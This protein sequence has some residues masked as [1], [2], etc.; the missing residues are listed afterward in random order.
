MKTSQN[1]IT[2][3]MRTI[4]SVSNNSSPESQTHTHTHNFFQIN[5]FCEVSIICPLY[6]IIYTCLLLQ[7]RISDWH[8]GGLSTKYFYAKLQEANQ[9]LGQYEKSGAPAGWSVNWDRYVHLLF[10]L[11]ITIRVGSYVAQVSGIGWNHLSNRQFTET[12]DCST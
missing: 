4:V 12:G 6:L 5:S 9:Q 2:T 7:T 3:K 11:D 8:A 1:V 10:L